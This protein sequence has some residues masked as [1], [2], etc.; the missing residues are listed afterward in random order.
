MSVSVTIAVIIPVVA[1]S[2]VLRSDTKEGS[3]SVTAS[4][5]NPVIPDD[6]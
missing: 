3:E 1:A 5:P 4:L 6:P 2:S